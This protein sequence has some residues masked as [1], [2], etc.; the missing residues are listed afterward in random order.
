TFLKTS[1]KI[2]QKL[3]EAKYN[4]LEIKE[5]KSCIEKKHSKKK[6]ALKKY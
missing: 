2:V 1:T 3:K 4:L 6:K 5:W